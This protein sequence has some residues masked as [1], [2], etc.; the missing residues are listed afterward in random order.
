MATNP[1]TIDDRNH[2]VIRRV[3]KAVTETA[4]SRKFRERAF[5]SVAA[6]LAAL[7]PIPYGPLAVFL[8]VL[9]AAE[10]R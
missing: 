8:L 7:A 1:E 9:A 2:P 6:A 4:G 10:G 5:I 3:V